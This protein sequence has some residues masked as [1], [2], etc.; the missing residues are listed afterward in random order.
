MR[1]LSGG[2]PPGLLVR[3]A[4]GEASVILLSGPGGGPLEFDFQLAGRL[5][6]ASGELES[7]GKMLVLKA[8]TLSAADDS[9]ARDA[10][11]EGR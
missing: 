11:K 4:D 10:S 6:A 2:V 5:V 3:G 7:D 8:E 1:C 9:P